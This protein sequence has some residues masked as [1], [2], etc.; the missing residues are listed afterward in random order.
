MQFR[1]VGMYVHEYQKPEFHTEMIY[2]IVTKLV[3]VLGLRE[4]CSTFSSL[5]YS[6]FPKISLHYACNY[7][8]YASH[9]YHYSII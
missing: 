8:F 6:E 3:L 9:C 1:D 7:S 5:F 4:L 2:F